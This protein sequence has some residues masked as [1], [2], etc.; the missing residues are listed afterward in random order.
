[1]STTPRAT[2]L[3]VAIVGIGELI[4]VPDVGDNLSS[5]RSRNGGD[6]FAAIVTDNAAN[7]VAMRRNVLHA[8]KHMVEF[9]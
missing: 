5:R 6:R 1:M 9:R 2:P 4:V 8:F 3:L 7:M